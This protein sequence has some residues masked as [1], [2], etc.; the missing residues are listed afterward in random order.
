VVYFGKTEAKTMRR[1]KAVIILLFCFLFISVGFVYSSNSLD[2]EKV[3]SKIDPLLISKKYKY[4]IIKVS[5]PLNNIVAVFINPSYRDFPNVIFF[6]YDQNSNDYNRVYEGLCLGIQDNPSGK[7]DLHTLGLGIDM[8]TDE[9]PSKF[10]S[11]SVRKI[12]ELGNKSG[13]VV[14]PYQDFTHM[15]MNTEFYTIDK[16]QYR[17]FAL[18]LIGSVYNKYP[19]DTCVMFDT[20]NLI[21]TQF[22]FDKGKY[23]VACKTDNNQFWMITFDGIDKD[24]KYLVNKKIEVKKL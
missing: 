10:E 22:I 6:K 4:E 15:H 19:K 11:E 9:G 24:N 21:D 3:Q 17:D 7:V 14:I 23:T 5:E 8:K 2:I 18:K 12:I 13:F 20:P 16:T 1:F